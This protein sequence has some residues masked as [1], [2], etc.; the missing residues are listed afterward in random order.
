MTATIVATQY[1]SL[2]GVIE[3][4][5]GMENTGLGDWTG[6]FNRGP[7]GD[8]FKEQEMFEASGVILGRRT[9]ESFAAVWPT[10]SSR[11]AEHINKIPKYLATR[12]RVQRGWAN[13]QVLEGDLVSSVAA[14]K[15]RMLGTFLIFGSASVCHTLFRA[16]LVDRLNLIIYPTILG[17]G[18]RLFPENH[19]ERFELID[20]RLFDDGL[21]LLQYKRVSPP[22]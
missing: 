21:V 11:Y 3:D 8:A 4:P 9:Y 5:V 15:R 14:L 20:D 22:Q 13:T 2:D 18:L 16:G 6:A 17:S 7:A 12:N 1:I 19:S 10:V